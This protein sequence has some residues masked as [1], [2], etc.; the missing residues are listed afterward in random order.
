MGIKIRKG[1]NLAQTETQPWPSII[2]TTSKRLSLLNGQ[3]G[4]R[5]SYRD[6]SGVVQSSKWLN[7]HSGINEDRLERRREMEWL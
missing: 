4:A 1:S 2:T 6:V 5:N 7:N 3:E